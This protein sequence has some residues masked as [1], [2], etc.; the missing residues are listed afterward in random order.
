MG[1]SHEC[2][3][4]S[5]VEALP[6]CSAPRIDVSG[7]SN[8][9]DKQVKASLRAALS[10]YT[11]FRDE[12]ERLKPSM[13]ITQSQCDVCAVD[14]EDVQTAVCEM[15]ESKPGIVSLEPI[16]LSD[17]WS[18]IQAVADALNDAEA[19]YRL[20]DSLQKR[21][22]DL[23]TTLPE[24]AVRPTVVC[25][26]WLEPLMPAGNWIPELVETAGGTSLLSEA[27]KHSPWMTWDDLASANPDFIVIMPCG[28]G[29]ERTKQERHLL[30]K[31][32]SWPG[33]KAVQNGHVFLTDGHQYFN[34]PGPRVVESAE[35]LAEI[36]HGPNVN[37]VHEGSGW[38]RCH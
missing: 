12:L 9:I 33:L 15:V 11:V 7:S 24:S 32:P 17:I 35:I 31:H 27:G 22:Q 25:I 3:F 23:T 18:D 34:R 28:F 2:D 21:L 8:E 16:A 36:L 38:V 20:I 4:P 37:F 5:G 29:I 1:R 14:L 19:G 10:I 13:I 6:V 26:E 30:T